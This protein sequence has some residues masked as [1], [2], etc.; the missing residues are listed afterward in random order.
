[1]EHRFWVSVGLLIARVGAAG[2]L[3]YGHGWKKMADF[4]QIA[5]TFPDPLGLGAPTS[6]ALAVF[7]EVV[8]AVAV[9][10]GLATRV[11][12]IPI[13]FM[14]LV[15]AFK[16]HAADPWPQKEFALIYAVPFLALIFTGPGRFSLDTIVWPK[17]KT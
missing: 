3:I 14:L 5:T 11:A 16:V 8:C 13:V 7:A 2:L 15:A 9:L 12:A 1:M 6:L 10:V 17:L 4:S